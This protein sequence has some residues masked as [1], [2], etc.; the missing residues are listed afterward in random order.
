MRTIIIL[1]ALI[2]LCSCNG[3]KKGTIQFKQISENEL[4]YPADS[5]FAIPH[6]K[7]WEERKRIHDSCMGSSYAV[8]AVF[9]RT[10]DTIPV[11]T[12]IDMKTMKVV[13]QSPFFSDSSQHL[14][15]LLIVDTKPCYERRA[16]DVP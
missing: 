12:I 2:L 6:G 8:N 1:L 16:I 5:S 10:R 3:S 14:S 9:M 11:G 7:I 13:K 4:N 15:S